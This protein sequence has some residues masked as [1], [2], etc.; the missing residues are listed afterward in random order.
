M[1]IAGRALKHNVH[2][3]II[4]DSAPNTPLAQVLFPVGFYHA[5]HTSNL[6]HAC[7]AACAACPPSKAL[8][9]NPVTGACEPF[10]NNSK[11]T[12]C[13]RLNHARGL[14]TSGCQG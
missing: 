6:Q 10:G 12:V 13:A 9:R 4:M 5:G 11:E 2:V 1:R 14:D 8:R 7:A 3:P